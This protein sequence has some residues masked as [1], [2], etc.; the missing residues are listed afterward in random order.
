MFHDRFLKDQLISNET[1][2]SDHVTC[3]Q[4]IRLEINKLES[5]FFSL[6]VMILYTKLLYNYSVLYFQSYKMSP[7]L[8]LTLYSLNCILSERITYFINIYNYCVF[9]QIHSE[10]QLKR[11]SFFTIK[12]RTNLKKNLF[13]LFN[14]LQ[15]HRPM[16]LI[17]LNDY[18]NIQIT[19]HFCNIDPAP[20]I[21]LNSS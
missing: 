16:C 12:F 17:K 11:K 8:F 14:D 19:T 18:F 9:P 13:V 4:Y 15:K 20:S 3:D 2:Y 10:L 7:I 21:F 6:F 1:L 5:Y